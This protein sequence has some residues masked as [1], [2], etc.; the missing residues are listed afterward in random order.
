MFGL[1]E[2]HAHAPGIVI[3]KQKISV[4]FLEISV[5]DVRK[6]LSVR[7][8]ELS[9]KRISK[10]SGPKQISLNFCYVLLEVNSLEK[11]RFESGFLNDGFPN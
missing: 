3:R 9:C 5:R 2:A 10:F 6:E 1:I 4:R 11:F 7:F 8:R